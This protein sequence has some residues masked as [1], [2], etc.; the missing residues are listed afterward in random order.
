[1]A[2]P[3]FAHGPE[4]SGNRPAA[5]ERP[6]RQHDQPIQHTGLGDHA[7]DDLGIDAQ[8]FAVKLENQIVKLAA[9][10][11]IAEIDVVVGQEEPAPEQDQRGCPHHQQ[12]AHPMAH[13]NALPQ[14]A[15]TG[16]GELEDGATSGCMAIPF[17]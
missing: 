4:P 8:H 15:G 5:S 9:Q 13:Q 17:R 12:I 16:N 10:H 14:R 1:M 2:L 7:G 11:H 6:D 3:A